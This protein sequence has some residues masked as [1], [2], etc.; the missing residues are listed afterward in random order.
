MRAVL[1]EI[2]GSAVLLSPDLL[3]SSLALPASCPSVGLLVCSLSA[4]VLA[5][6][7]G[8]V[9]SVWMGGRGEGMAL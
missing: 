2:S 9:I 8:L 4:E 7:K 5:K 1:E 3:S 6:M